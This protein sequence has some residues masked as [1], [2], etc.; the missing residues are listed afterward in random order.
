LLTPIAAGASA[1]GRLRFTTATSVTQRLLAKPI[2]HLRI[3]DRTVELALE[4][5]QGTATT[6]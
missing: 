2:A 3:A 6:G 1:T 4:A 5:A